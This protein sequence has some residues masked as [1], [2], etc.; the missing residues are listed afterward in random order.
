MMTTSIYSALLALI[1]IILSIHVIKGRRLMS[2]GIGDFDNLD[3]KRRIRAHANFIEYT[4]IFL[5]LLGLAEYQ[6]LLHIWV[7]FFG[8]IF[9]I[10]RIMHAYSLLYAEKYKNAKLLSLPKWRIAGMIG[11]FMCLLIL[12]VILLTQKV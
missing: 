11:S 5:I 6:G 2:I 7:H 8:I 9:L 12:S 3:M 10:S 1:F 4:P